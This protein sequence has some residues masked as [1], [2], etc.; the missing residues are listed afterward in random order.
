MLSKITLNPGDMS[1]K[2]PL[3]Q[4]PLSSED[5]YAEVATK[6]PRTAQCRRELLSF[7]SFCTSG[8]NATSSQR[9]VK[10]VTSELWLLA[11]VSIL[12]APLL[13]LIKVNLMSYADPLRV[14]ERKCST[15]FI[16]PQVLEEVASVSRVRISSPI[17]AFAV[18]CQLLNLTHYRV[19]WGHQIPA[20]M[21]NCLLYYYRGVLF[22]SSFHMSTTQARETLGKEQLLDYKSNREFIT[23]IS[24]ASIPFPPLVF[25]QWLTSQQNSP[26]MLLW[27]HAKSRNFLDRSIFLK[28]LERYDFWSIARKL[29]ASCFDD[30]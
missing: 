1:P 27:E 25:K 28:N 12:I 23:L 5:W 7:A 18:R 29:F 11:F 16:F 19:C 22:M 14:A 2:P 17:V 15:Q 30:S 6:L 4:C 10:R 8:V 9:H 3:A 21:P 20:V 26:R 24:C 13:S